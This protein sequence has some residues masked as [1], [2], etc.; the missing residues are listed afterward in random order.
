MSPLGW[1]DVLIRLGAAALL[2]G[3]VGLE[4]EKVS[5]P[6]GLRTHILVC[7]GAA[8]VM[9]ISTDMYAIYKGLAPVDPGRI[10]AQVVSGIGFLG[11]GTIMREGA[12]VRGLTTAASLWV[13]AAVGLAVGA[14]LYTGAVASA[15]IVLGTLLVLSKVE[16]RLTR[17]RYR[18]LRVVAHDMP[19]LVGKIGTI[20]GER[21]INIKNV[22]ME[23]DTSE[24]DSAVPQVVL[25]FY[26]VF[27][28][29]TDP[30]ECVHEVKR[31]P[32]VVEAEVDPR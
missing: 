18:L 23:E 16:R 6:A 29:G 1:Q 17:R 31:I 32:G 19:G 7:V 9:M 20:L 15:L 4:R 25:E 12:T 11:A 3:L 28:P 10:A 24:G 26:L 13:I 14:G 5:R 22:E 27:P 8:L 30:S 21:R 2:G